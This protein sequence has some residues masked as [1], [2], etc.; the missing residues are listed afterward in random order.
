MQDYYLRGDEDTLKSLLQTAEVI[1][2]DA[3][4]E[5]YSVDVIGCI[6][7]AEGCHVNLR[8][9]LSDAQL[10]TLSSVM[11]EPPQNPVRVWA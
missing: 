8:G 1:T 11:I 9:V 2:E 3:P 10:E 5:G 4:A 7:G 6:E